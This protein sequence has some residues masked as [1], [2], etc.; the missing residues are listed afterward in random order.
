MI[1]TDKGFV[2]C[3]SEALRMPPYE[4]VQFRSLYALCFHVRD[5][6]PPD[7]WTKRIYDIRGGRSPADEYAGKMTLPWA[8]KKSGLLSTLPTRTV[9]LGAIPSRSESLNPCDFVY[10]LASSI[11]ESFDLDLQPNYLS[12]KANASM[13]KQAKC[14]R[15][16]RLDILSTYRCR[17]LLFPPEAILIVD[18][19]CTSGATFLNICMAISNAVST[20]NKVPTYA[21]SLAKH[22]SLGYWK[23][24]GPD[25]SNSHIDRETSSFWRSCVRE[26][27]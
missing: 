1:T 4:H 18:D 12:K 14:S 5:R 9:V 3:D 26:Y 23:D 15:D 21:I 24:S 7:P 17:K 22:E 10:Q 2:I 6:T 13:H 11:A 8:L 25:L 20:R 27:K 19:V 16:E